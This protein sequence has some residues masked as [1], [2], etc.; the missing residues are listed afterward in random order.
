M[1][2]SELQKN[3]VGLEF[4]IIS[5]RSRDMYYLKHVIQNCSRESMPFQRKNDAL[6]CVA[7]V[8]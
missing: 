5:L 8:R 1:Y 3:K 4:R 6:R 7:K 2:Y